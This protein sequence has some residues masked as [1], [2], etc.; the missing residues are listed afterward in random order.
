MQS[1]R[2]T[3]FRRIKEKTKR[4]INKFDNFIKIISIEGGIIMKQLICLL[5][6]HLTIF[7]AGIV[8]LIFL[9]ELLVDIGIPIII[10]C[11]IVVAG[12]ALMYALDWIFYIKK[13]LIDFKRFER[14]S[15]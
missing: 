9:G 7:L 4:I 8:V 11:F 2:T 10:S 6:A 5:P 1:N 15:K 12:I 3:I 13:L 14:R